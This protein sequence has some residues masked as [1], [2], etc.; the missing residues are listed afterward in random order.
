MRAALV[1]SIDY[2]FGGKR[3]LAKLLSTFSTR[4]AV[5]PTSLDGSICFSEFQQ[6]VCAGLS[7]TS[8]IFLGHGL[9]LLLFA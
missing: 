2:S 7:W 4:D 8:Q 6:R 5:R 9:S 3:G 1:L